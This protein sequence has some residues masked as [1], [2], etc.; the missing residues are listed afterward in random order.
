MSGSTLATEAAFYEA[1]RAAL[2]AAHDGRFVL[3]KDD[4]IIG[5]FDTLDDALDVGYA[6]FAN[7]GFLARKIA[8][9][10]EVIDMVTPFLYEP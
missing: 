5:I 10:D 2:V 4:D 1:H 8:S 6:R 7:T 3:V 9:V